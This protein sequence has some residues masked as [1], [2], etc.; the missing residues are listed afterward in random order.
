MNK[1]MLA[2]YKTLT[3]SQK[4]GFECFDAWFTNKGFKKP[5]KQILRIGGPAGTGKSFFIKFLIDYYH[6][7][8]DNCIV[9]AYTG[10]AV[11]VL[12]LNGIFSKTIHAS[13]MHTISEQMRDANGELMFRGD[14]PIMTQRYV[15]MK[16][17]RPGIKLIIIDESSFLPE[18][19]QK[20]IQKFGLPIL[21][22]GDPI[23]LPP[24][25]GRQCFHMNNLDCY[26]TDPMR[27]AK[28]SEILD[29]ATR[30]REECKVDIHAY[31]NQV[32][33]LKQKPTVEDSFMTFLPHIWHSDCVIT[34]TNKQ[35]QVVVDMYRRRLLHTDSPYP[36]RGD[37]LICRRNNWNLVL[38]DFPLTT[39]TLGTARSIVGRSDIFRNKKQYEVD[40]APDFTSNDYYD[41]LVC[42]SD[43][44][45][46]PFGNKQVDPFNNGN[47]LE[48][49]QAITVHLAQGS[50]FPYVLYFD[51][52]M[53]RGEYT[54]R[55]RYTAVTRA[56]QFLTYLMSPYGKPF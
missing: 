4:R 6:L 15:P 28:D 29:L 1:E 26:F 51:G 46:Q 54:M 7:T 52:Y 37:R 17:L 11:S 27:Q 44:L 50:Q 19:L 18:N 9:S 39:G 5:G 56:Q 13:F 16:T 45:L 23:Q 33:I 24:V 12:Q 55:L 21:E 20:M 42:D 2:R 10:R 25:A 31:G 8:P 34:A 22:T 36:V 53:D 32:E 30:I 3:P 47:K 38:G 49:A 41:G 43:F 14:I 48:Y 35:R 40:F